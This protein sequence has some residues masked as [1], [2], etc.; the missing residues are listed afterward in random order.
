M[1]Q[2]L[3][4]SSP[5]YS[6]RV[7]FPQALVRQKLVGKEMPPSAPKADIIMEFNSGF[8]NQFYFDAGVYQ[9]AGINQLSQD[10]G[11]DQFDFLQV[12]LHEQIHGLGFVTSFDT[13]LSELPESVQQKYPIPFGWSKETLLTPPMTMD[14]NNTKVVSIG[15]ITAFDYFLA[16]ATPKALYR[17][18]EITEKTLIP[19]FVKNIHKESASEVLRVLMESVIVPEAIVMT[20]SS[21]VKPTSEAAPIILQSGQ[22]Y[23]RGTSIV[24]FD[25]FVYAATDDFLMRPELGN[26]TTLQNQMSRFGNDLKPFGQNTAKLIEHLGYQLARNAREKSVQQ[27][28]EMTGS[29]STLFRMELTFFMPV[30]ITLMLI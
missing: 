18:H 23:V 9:E 24:H 27:R 2:L 10:I 29:A 22:P 1:W 4:D 14:E 20:F 11:P 3:M 8:Q 21:E 15:P 28:V 16:T 6:D 26:G 5:M 19:F 12:A 30:L 25:R 17:W 7:V 13:H